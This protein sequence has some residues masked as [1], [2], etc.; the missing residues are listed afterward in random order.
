ME[1]G[2]S[3]FAVGKLTA[4]SLD[5][6]LRHGAPLT[7]RRERPW[8]PSR[9][10]KVRRPPALRRGT[11]SIARGWS[12]G[13]LPQLVAMVCPFATLDSLQQL[14]GGIEDCEDLD[15]LRLPHQVQDR[16]LQ[17]ALHCQGAENRE[18]CAHAVPV[19]TPARPARAGRR[20]PKLP[21]L[22]RT[23]IPLPSARCIHGT[24]GNLIADRR[25]LKSDRRDHHTG[26]PAAGGTMRVTRD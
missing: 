11:C 7:P 3:P 5:V 9:R 22:R 21:D 16:G 6:P 15:T 25:A 4:V 13:S 18:G 8:S 14:G 24:P 2:T 26:C 12:C 1:D 17:R 23:A 19:A 20:S 10:D